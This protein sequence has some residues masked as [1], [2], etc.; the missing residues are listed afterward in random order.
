ML[1]EMPNWEEGVCDIPPASW[2]N[3]CVVGFRMNI[4]IARAARLLVWRRGVG[5]FHSYD[6]LYTKFQSCTHLTS[7]S[8]LRASL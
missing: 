8:H 6:H 1:L 2:M 5:C 3:S 4:L 7:L